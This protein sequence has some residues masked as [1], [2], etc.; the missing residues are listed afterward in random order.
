VRNRRQQA[1]ALARRRIVD[2][3]LRD[4]ISQAARAHG[5]A[6]S[7]VQR[8]LRRHQAGG[9]EA[10]CNQPRGC[11]E[12]IAA[13]VK[14]LI[15]ELK[16]AQPRRSTQKIRQLM[17][18]MGLPLSRQTVWR[19]LAAKGLA[20]LQEPS[21]LQRFVRSEP[22][23]L[24]QLD[25]M[26]EERLPCGKVHLVAALDDHSRFCVGARF[27]RRKGEADILGALAGFLQRWGLPKRS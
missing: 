12:P 1:V 19:V 7:T 2:D 4:G 16:L 11:R 24:W 14:E 17:E 18:E 21:P 22:N 5:C 3:A 6:R 23:A 20:S 10:L 15:V 25:L 27:V 9:L 13:E 26:E 8:L